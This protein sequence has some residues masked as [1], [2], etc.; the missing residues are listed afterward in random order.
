M[1]ECAMGLDR[2]QD[3]SGS[4]TIFVSKL[5][6]LA[7]CTVLR[8]SRSHLSQNLDLTRGRT[9]Y[10]FVIL[11]HRRLS[12]QNNDTASRSTVILTQCWTSPN[13]FKQCDGSIDSL[14]LRCRSRLSMSVVFD[15][16]W[17]WRQ[18][19]AGQSDPYPERKPVNGKVQNQIV[20]L[21][22]LISTSRCEARGSGLGR[23]FSA[24]FAG[25]RKL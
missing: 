3:F 2:T 25:V 16:Y 17:W 14:T 11:F 13:M 21:L 12:L 5:L 19:F 9:L 7:A 8:L 24:H 1:I 18:E 6:H 23:K 10:F 22:R 15:C 20:L 4:A